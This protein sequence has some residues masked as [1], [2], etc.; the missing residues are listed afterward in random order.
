MNWVK[1]YSSNNLQHIE[2]LKHILKENGIDAIVMN[3]QDSIYVTIGEID[4]MVSVND[5]LRSK[6]IISETK[7]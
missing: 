3:K 6:K 4:L 1:V 7:L 5:V 2:L